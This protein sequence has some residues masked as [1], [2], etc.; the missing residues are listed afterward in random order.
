MAAGAVVAVAVPVVV[1]AVPV[2][3][4]AVPVVVAAVAGD[5][6]DYFTI[7]FIQKLLGGRNDV[8]LYKG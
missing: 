4:A 1:V 3:V 7:V 2:V 5:N 6:H 8:F